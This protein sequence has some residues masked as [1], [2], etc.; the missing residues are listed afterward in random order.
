MFARANSTGLAF[1][2]QCF[3]F[4]G[5]GAPLSLLLF[6]SGFFFSSIA[7]PAAHWDGPFSLG[8]SAWGTG[9]YLGVGSTSLL[10]RFGVDADQTHSFTNEVATVYGWGR[11]CSPF[12]CSSLLLGWTLVLRTEHLSLSTRTREKKHLQNRLHGPCGRIQSKPTI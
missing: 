4:G 1:V 9:S 12:S 11:C 2:K 5:S 8:A 10:A 6:L 7:F 3:C